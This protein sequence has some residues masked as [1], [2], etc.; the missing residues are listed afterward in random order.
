MINEIMLKFLKIEHE[1]EFHVLN[2][3]LCIGA[4]SI[5]PYTS[6]I[7]TDCNVGVIRLIAYTAVSAF[8]FMKT[9]KMPTKKKPLIAL[10]SFT[11]ISCAI[12]AIGGIRHKAGKLYPTIALATGTT[13]GTFIFI[14]TLKA[15]RQ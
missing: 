5:H 2:G 8:A 3:C 1:G 15:G 13:L 14:D 4:L 9:R 12:L 7:T 6:V 10:C 11:T